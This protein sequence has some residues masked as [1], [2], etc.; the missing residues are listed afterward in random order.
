MYREEAKELES[1]YQKSKIPFTSEDIP[2][3][4]KRYIPTFCLDQFRS[5][6]V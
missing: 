3:G 4:I 1:Q 2:A 5:C 6:F